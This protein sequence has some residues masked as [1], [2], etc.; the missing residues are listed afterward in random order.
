MPRL[1]AILPLSS[2][3]AERVS[4]VIIG[5]GNRIHGRIHDQ[6]HDQIHSPIAGCCFMS[7]KGSPYDVACMRGTVQ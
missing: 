4:A 1:S 6:M 7:Q 5:I 3:F 2:E